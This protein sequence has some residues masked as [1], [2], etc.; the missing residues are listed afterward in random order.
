MPAIQALQTAR[1][2]IEEFAETGFAV[3]PGV[4]DPEEVSRARELCESFS[5]TL[6]VPGDA[7]L[8]T[9]ELGGLLVKAPVVESFRGLLG[10]NYRLYPN[11]TVRKSLY[12]GWHVDLAF[13]GPGRQYVWKHDFAHIQAA[14]YLQDNDA[15]TGGGIDVVPG[16]HIHSLDAYGRATPDFP[17][18]L[19]AA[20]RPPVRVDSRAGDLVLWHAR[21]WHA[22]TP[23]HLGPEERREPE[24]AKLGIF[25]SAGRDD[26][27]ENNRYLSHLSLKRVHRVD[28]EVRPNP[29]FTEMLDRKF[30]DEYP[31][32][33]VDRMREAK[34][35]VAN[36]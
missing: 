12:V 16:S 32:W 4:L 8:E 14:V 34:F 22:S 24:Q 27:Y 13:A 2:G 17:A 9:K 30:P 7:F 35:S 11:M 10:E 25:L 26:L 36:F 18:A 6:E 29:R 23:S 3:V 20:P 1:P 28:G 31:E 21:L 15:D 19:R 33:L 5:E